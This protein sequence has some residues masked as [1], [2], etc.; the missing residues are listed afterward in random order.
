[1][2]PIG[3]LPAPMG[4]THTPTEDTM[5][6]IKKMLGL[7]EKRHVQPVSITDDNFAAEVRKSELPVLLDIWSPGCAPCRQLEPVV[8]ELAARYEGRLKVCEMNAASA[9]RT[10]ARLNVRGT[11]TVIYFNKAN[12]VERVVGFRA[13]HYHQEIIETL[14][15]PPQQVAQPQTA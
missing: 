7:E 6:W 2:N 8:M 12:E 14:V 5:G 10:A 4:T 15:P 13:G 9:P 3:A 11:P 1:M